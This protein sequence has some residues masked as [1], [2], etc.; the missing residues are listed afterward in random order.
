MNS[1]FLVH[2][3]D[4][5]ADILTTIADNRAFLGT[6]AALGAA[7][8]WYFAA[9]NDKQVKKIRGWPIV[10]QWA[11]FTK[12][13]DNCVD[14]LQSCFQK[15]PSESLFGFNI[16]EHNIVAMRGENARKT[17]FD[18][19][20][21]NFTEG[22]RI[23]FGGVPMVQDIVEDA[24]EKGDKERASDFIRRLTMLLRPDRLTSVNPQ[25]MADLEPNMVK[26]GTTGKFDPFVDIYSIVFQATIRT[27]GCR[28]IADS[29]ENCQKLEQLYWHVEKGS[30]ATSMLL[31]WFP[32]QARKMKMAATTEIYMWLDSII[33]ARQK[34]DRREN[35]ALQDM[36]DS[37]ESTPTVV[38]TIMGAL[39]AGIVNSGLMAA[40][41]F[42]LLDQTPEWRAKVTQ[43][44]KSLLNKYAPLS[45]NYA[46]AAERFSDAPLEAW[47]NEM[48]I[49]EDCLRETIRYAFNLLS[50]VP[51][52]Q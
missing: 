24:F 41:V 51:M 52:A 40:W 47:E 14:F 12:L 36:I 46:S 8:V 45:G 20:D 35:D 32:S 15:L 1:S 3:G 49:L 37:G 34:E 42:I 11:F 30:T 18:R 39:F 38:Q 17:F 31:P 5:P 7:L 19:R 28:E 6:T 10:G 25:I 48:P 9:S 21:L 50:Q 23:L 44:L 43:E 27:I 13:M 22:Y 16:L 2:L 33:K 26:W 29:V 4:Q